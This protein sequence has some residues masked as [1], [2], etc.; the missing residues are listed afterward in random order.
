MQGVSPRDARVLK[1]QKTFQTASISRKG[2]L[3][4]QS[5]PSKQQNPAART[6]GKQKG[7]S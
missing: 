7:L 3:K 4:T 1:E 5:H 2:R 6:A